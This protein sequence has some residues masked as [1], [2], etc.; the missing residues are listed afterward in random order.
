MDSIYRR[1][2]ALSRVHGLIIG[3][4]K[5]ESHAHLNLDGC[6]ND[7]ESMLEYFMGLGIPRN[8]FMCLFDERATQKGILDVFK[9]HL[10]ENP[11]IE[12]HDPLI[13]YFVGRG[14]CIEAPV[15]WQA[16][17]GKL[18][19]ILSH[20][21]NA[22][23]ER[24]GHGFVDPT[25]TLLLHEIS[26]ERGNT[27]TAGGE[28]RNKSYFK[29]H[30]T[31]PSSSPSS[32]SPSSSSSS[33]PFFCPTTTTA[34]S[35]SIPVR[36][37]G[38]FDPSAGKP[39]VGASEPLAGTSEP[40]ARAKPPTRAELPAGAE[41][42][43]GAELPA[44]ASKPLAGANKPRARAE[45]PAGAEPPAAGTEPPTGASKPPTRAEPPFG[46]A[47]PSGAAPPAGASKP[48]AGFSKPLAE[49]VEICK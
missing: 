12:P 18:E 4:N 11:D 38:G 8:R 30:S 2:L 49:A 5:Y 21:T 9:S 31:R 37:N 15:G 43:A 44:G 24:S 34:T 40:L 36:T 13:V 41:P 6:V 17:D 10:V 27:I 45:P 25:F 7:A 23:G 35:C 22:R 48:P 14:C 19:I 28:P 29:H 42:P 16:T 39:L 32:S 47:P 3:I 1:K 46:A 33:S 26:H 20:D